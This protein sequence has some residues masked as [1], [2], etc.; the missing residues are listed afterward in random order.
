MQ[1]SMSYQRHCGNS[2]NAVRMTN[3]YVIQRGTNMLL[4]EILYFNRIHVS[5]ITLA[6][7]SGTPYV[8]HIALDKHCHHVGSRLWNLQIYSQQMRQNVQ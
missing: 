6:N 8:W 5:D 4:V 3:H 2:T 1:I 7:H